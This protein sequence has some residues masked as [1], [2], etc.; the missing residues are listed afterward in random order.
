MI[1]AHNLTAMN[2]QRQFQIVGNSKAKSSEKLSSGYRINRSADDAAGL[3]ISEKMRRQIRGLDQGAENIQDGISLLQVADGAL[4]EVNDMLHRMTELSVQAANGT[5]NT[6][7]RQA[8]QSEINQLKTEITRIGKTT[9]FNDLLIFDDMYG[10]DDGGSVTQLVAS[11]AADSGYLTE[12]I[13]VNGYW[14][15]A[16]TIDFTNINSQNISKLNGQGFSF[17]CS[18][19][20]DEVFD[21]TFYT[22]GTPSS[23]SDLVGKIP[24]YYNLDISDCTSGSDIIDKLYSYVKS[25][26][27]TGNSADNVNKLPNAL[28]VS[29]SN[30]MLKS[31]DGNKLIIYANRRIAGT[32]SFVEDGYATEEEAKAAYPSTITGVK[33]WAGAIDCSHLTAVYEDDKINEI[34]IQCSSNARE[35]ETFHTHRMNSVILGIDNISVLTE[36]SAA[37]AIEA[38][39]KASLKIGAQ[40]SELGGFQNQLESAYKVNLNVSENTTAAESRIRDTDMAK[41]MVNQSKHSILEQVGVSMMSQANQLGQRVLSLVQ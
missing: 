6:E 5:N 10:N 40:R 9:S 30:Y 8:I 29:H 34:K 20:C 18:R 17:S 35:Y 31:D 11:S 4:A 26:P 14:F 19:G 41:E 16:A 1:V 7:D 22:D 37:S 15:P 25:N 28:N 23:G 33:P 2:A 13:Q 36:R 32:N 27:P 12:A 38:I 39:K 24:H 3:A 21:F